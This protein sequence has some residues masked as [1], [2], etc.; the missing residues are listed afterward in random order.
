M[1]FRACA[2]A[3]LLWF[4]A[5]VQ[6]SFF[7]SLGSPWAAF[8]FLLACG[9]TILHER[10]LVWGV[11][12]LTLAGF[13]LEWRGLGFG[14]IV[15]YA[16]AAVVTAVLI[17]SVFAKRSLAGLMGVSTVGTVAFLFLRFLG[18]VVWNLS[19][20]EPWL[21]GIAFGEFFFVVVAVP[22]AVVVLSLIRRR[23]FRFARERV[24]Q[25]SMYE[26]TS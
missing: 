19:H 23:F 22:V 10:S 20:A 26:F 25:S 1:I 21:L 11:W 12:W 17:T 16:G 2:Y 5:L 6:A 18:V 13:L 24:T 4:G 7:A 3:V 8:P 9:I 14:L 15:A